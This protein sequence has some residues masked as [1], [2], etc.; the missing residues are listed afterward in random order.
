MANSRSGA[1][2]EVAIGAAGNNPSYVVISGP[3]NAFSGWNVTPAE[4]TYDNTSGGLTVTRKGNFVQR[5]AAFTVAENTTTIPLFLGQNGR[6]MQVRNR[7]RG[8]TAG[9]PNEVYQAIAQVSRVFNA[10]GARMFQVDCTIDG[11]VAITSQ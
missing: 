7:P 6:R 9:T 1:A 11:A 5:T 8:A 4:Q 2:Q 3:E 10:R